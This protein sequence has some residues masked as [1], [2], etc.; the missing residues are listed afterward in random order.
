V[1]L[2]L[3]LAAALVGTAVAAAPGGAA[4]VPLPAQVCQEP[5][6]QT[7]STAQPRLQRAVVAGVP[8]AVVL[9]VGYG[10]DLRRYP[11]VYLLHGAQ[12]DED[13]W[14]EY[15]GLMGSTARQGPA[16]RAVVVLP[17]MGVVTGFATDWRDGHRR[18]ASFLATTLVRWTDAHYRTIVDRRARAI[19][20]YSGGALSAVHVAER[21]PQVFGSVGV[22]SGPTDL[23]DPVSEPAT[24]ATLSAE[25]LCAGDDLGAAGP[26]GD[27]VTDAAA[28]QAAD[29]ALHVDRLRRTAV[30]VSSGNGAPCDAVDAAN[31]AYPTAAT[32]PQMRRAATKLHAALT[33]AG[34]RHTNQERACGLHWWTTWTPALQDFW[35]VAAAT[36]RP[37]LALRG[38]G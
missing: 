11:V 33:A 16:G 24:W 32:E 14:I 4:P 21:A 38:P 22:L 30:F 35:V 6:G 8:V 3:S 19:A 37:V 12:G 1:H 23:T 25:A 13:S 17:K 36:W 18:D 28:W 20:G 15:G 34:V 10:R 29:P 5:G 7:D 27:P 9:P 31:L 26:L 2:R